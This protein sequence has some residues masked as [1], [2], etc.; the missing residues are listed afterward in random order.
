VE[1]TGDG[2]RR[3]RPPKDQAELDQMIQRWFQSQGRSV[4]RDRWNEP[5]IYFRTP[6]NDPRDIYYQIVSKGPDR[7]PGTVDD[8]VLIRE[9]SSRHINRNPAEVMA[10]AT[11]RKRQLDRETSE[12]IRQLLEIPRPAPEEKD[13]SKDLESSTRELARM[14]EEL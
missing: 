4:I 8:I 11:E 1:C 14:L 5:F 9:E 10:Q 2:S 12:R 3:K 7:L 6:R 13:G